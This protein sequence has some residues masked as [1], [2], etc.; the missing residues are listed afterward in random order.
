M[1]TDFADYLADRFGPDEAEHIVLSHK[2]FLEAYRDFADNLVHESELFVAIRSGAAF[3]VVPKGMWAVLRI[4]NGFVVQQDV[5]SRR[6][7]VARFADKLARS[8]SELVGTSRRG[9]L[10]LIRQHGVNVLERAGG[11]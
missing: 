5:M 3:V 2:V 7:V 8:Q 4:E 9:G 10:V 11:R 1:L 6:M